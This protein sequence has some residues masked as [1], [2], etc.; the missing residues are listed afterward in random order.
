M[1]VTNSERASAPGERF[2][3]HRAPAPLQNASFADD[4]RS[5]LSA[6]ENS[7]AAWGQSWV[8]IGLSSQGDGAGA[9]RPSSRS[10]T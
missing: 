5:G 2:T 3:L 4:V 7:A 9:V 1:F 8:G 6:A 10:T